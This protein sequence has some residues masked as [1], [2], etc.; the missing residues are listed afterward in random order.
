MKHMDGKQQIKFNFY[1]IIICYFMTKYINNCLRYL[2]NYL[3][4]IYNGL[5]I[6]IT[7]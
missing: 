3:Y 7:K 2:N 6:F 5:F 4:L 1:L